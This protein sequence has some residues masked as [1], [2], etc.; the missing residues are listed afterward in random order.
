MSSVNPKCG[1]LSKQMDLE[2]GEVDVEFSYETSSTEVEVKTSRQSFKNASGDL[3]EEKYSPS[4]F[5]SKGSSRNLNKFQANSCT[6]LPTVP[7]TASISK[8]EKFKS[9]DESMRVWWNELEVANSSESFISDLSKLGKCEIFEHDHRPYASNNFNPVKKICQSVTPEVSREETYN[10]ATSSSCRLIRVNNSSKEEFL[11]AICWKSRR[12]CLLCCQGEKKA[13]LAVSI[14]IFICL[15]LWLLVV[16][17]NV[18]YINGY[19]LSTCTV[20]IVLNGERFNRRVTNVVLGL[21][22]LFHLIFCFAMLY[23]FEN[24]ASNWELSL[25]AVGHIFTSLLLFLT[26]WERFQIKR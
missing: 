8:N 12:G 25:A 5:E 14:W 2:R 4:Y 7:S 18:L 13:D 10:A 17:C 11:R 19:V 6:H 22:S 1:K 24:L 26:M 16:K 20:V 9:Y 15:P 23:K 21:N 3:T